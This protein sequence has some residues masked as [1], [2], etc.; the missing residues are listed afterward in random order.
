M[1]A[2]LSDDFVWT[3]PDGTADPTGREVRGHAAVREA[4]RQ[5]F[6]DHP[7]TAPAFSD[8]GVEVLGDVLLVRYRVCASGGATGKVDACGIEIYRVKEGKLTHKDVYWKQ[9]A[10]PEG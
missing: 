10:W 7:A 8:I 3:L 2:C 5:R 9:V 1:M 6:F 4:F